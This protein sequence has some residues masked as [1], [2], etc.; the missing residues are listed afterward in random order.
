MRDEHCQI[1]SSGDYPDELYP[2]I[3]D[4][5]KRFDR[6]STSPDGTGDDISEVTEPV[7]YYAIW[8]NV[9]TIRLKIIWTTDE[10]YGPEGKGFRDWELT[11]TE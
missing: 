6:W 10:L 11:G 7:T 4:A 5:S 3:D 8:V 1:Y 2:E 9:Y